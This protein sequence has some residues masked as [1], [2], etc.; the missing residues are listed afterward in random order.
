[1]TDSL[2]ER[3]PAVYTPE[4]LEMMKTN[5]PLRNS[6]GTPANELSATYIEW[7]RAKHLHV[8]NWSA[9]NDFEDEEETTGMSTAENH[10]QPVNP[11]IDDISEILKEL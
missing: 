3:F 5:N 7:M 1:M 6:D 11:T 2:E 4:G 9:L 10:I 8:A